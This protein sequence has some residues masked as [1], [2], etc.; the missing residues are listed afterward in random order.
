LS[1]PCVK[2]T[3]GKRIDSVKEAT[4]STKMLAQG[5]GAVAQHSKGKTTAGFDDAVHFAQHMLWI[6]KQVERSTAVDNVE[7]IGFEGEF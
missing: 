4:G 5:I 2:V 3:L 7:L 6:G 1:E